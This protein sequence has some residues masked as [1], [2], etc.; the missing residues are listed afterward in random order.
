MVELRSCHTEAFDA[1]DRLITQ[2]HT[3]RGETRT[4]DLPDLI[5]R[6]RRL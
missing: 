4:D 6:L 3:L 1:L 5:R 2:Y